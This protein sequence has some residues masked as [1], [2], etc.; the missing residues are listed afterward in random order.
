LSASCAGFIG[1]R[2]DGQLADSLP[3]TALFAEFAAAS[4]PIAQHYEH[5]EYSKAMRL[6]MALAD[7]ANRYI[8]DNKPP[9]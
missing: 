4:E 2:F 7:Q 5:R 9:E 8:D 3:D 1:K 6:I